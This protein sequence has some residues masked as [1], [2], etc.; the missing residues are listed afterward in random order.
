[1]GGFSIQEL[2]YSERSCL[3]QETHCSI[4]DPME[5]LDLMPYPT[6]IDR[7]AFQRNIGVRVLPNGV[8]KVTAGKTTSKKVISEFLNHCG[9]W[10]Y[11]SLDEYQSLRERHPPK[12]YVMGEKFLFRGKE[13]TLTF[14]PTSNK[15]PFFKTSH[16][17]LILYLP[18]EDVAHQELVKALRKFY[19]KSGSEQ[20]TKSVEYH[21]QLMNL[22]PKALSFRSQKTRWGSC[23]SDGNVSLNWRLIVAPEVC[24]NYVVIHELSH[25]KYQNHSRKFWD[26]VEKYSPGW[27][28]H[29]KWLRDHQYA[30]DFLAKKS[31][32]HA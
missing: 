4:I 17:E 6:I 14:S 9:V 29:R 16:N 23:S 19:K 10:I 18:I 25:L 3:S 7:R 1:M 11:K 12:K 24:L 30:F 26:L 15:R 32:L 31:E 20:L 13:H 5:S 2:R 8:V 27:K 21:S 22:Y 28:A